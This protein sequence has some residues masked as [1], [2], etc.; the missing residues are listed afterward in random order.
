MNHLTRE[1]SEQPE[2]LR[3]TVEALAQDKSLTQIG[4]F[5]RQWQTQTVILTGMGSS[6]AAAYY[7]VYLLGEYGIHSFAVDTSELLHYRQRMVE[8]HTLLVVISQS[9]QSAELCKLLDILACTVPIIG[10]TNTAESP[11]ARRST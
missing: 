11:L 9:G 6:L 1:L 10:I 2:A 7:G 5:L 3:C 4:E 8:R